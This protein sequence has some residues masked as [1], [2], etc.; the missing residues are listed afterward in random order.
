M[1]IIIYWSGVLDGERSKLGLVK[2][3]SVDVF[4]R[5]FAGMKNSSVVRPDRT[6]IEL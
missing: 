4:K 5:A 6:P 3:I 1:E 2:E